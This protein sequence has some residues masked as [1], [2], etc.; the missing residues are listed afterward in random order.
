MMIGCIHY[1]NCWYS[2]TPWP[3][4]PFHISGILT[5]VSTGHKGP[6]MRSLDV[7]LLLVLAIEQTVEMPVIRDIM[8]TQWGKYNK[9][10]K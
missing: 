2:L 5:R 1:D 3:G 4:N 9:F 8:A 10:K 6:V 7:S